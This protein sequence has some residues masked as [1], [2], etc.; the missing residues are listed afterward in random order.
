MKGRE[1]CDWTDMDSWKLYI[2]TTDGEYADDDADA[3]A[4]ADTGGNAD[5]GGETLRATTTTSLS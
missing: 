2:D 1:V 5:D 3:D 4:D